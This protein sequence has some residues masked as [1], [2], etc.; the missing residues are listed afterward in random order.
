MSV[1]DDSRLRAI[2]EIALSLS[3]ID[4]LR[5]L[6]DRPRGAQT[7]ALLDRELKFYA[8]SESEEAYRAHYEKYEGV[9]FAGPVQQFVAGDWSKDPRFQGILYALRHTGAKKVLDFG[10]STGHITRA[11]AREMPNVQFIGVDLMPQAISWFNS[12]APSNARGILIDHVYIGNQFD[13]IICAEVLEHLRDPYAVLDQLAKDYLAPGGSFLCTLPLGPWESRGW[14]A[15]DPYAR[16]HLRHWG[17]FELHDVFGP[18]TLTW[19]IGA[20]DLG[21]TITLSGPRVGM[22]DMTAKLARYERMAKGL[23]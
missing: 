5:W 8:F 6:A 12:R 13:V 18:T 16:E 11:L 10:C 15:E 7:Q 9:F 14:T 22:V 23:L 3:D 20:P 1:I 4:F 21:H 2:A 19:H 17:P